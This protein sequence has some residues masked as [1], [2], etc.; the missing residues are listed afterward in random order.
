MAHSVRLYRVAWRQVLIYYLPA[1]SISAGLIAIAQLYLAQDRASAFGIT[2]VLWVFLPL[3]LASLGA[4]LASVVM[5]E[6]LVG[7]KVSPAQA[8]RALP[9]AAGPAVAASVLLF[10]PVWFLIMFVFNFVG[11]ALIYLSAGPPIYI[12]AVALENLGGRAALQ[13]ARGLLADLAGRAFVYLFGIAFGIMLV[14]VVASVVTGAIGASTGLSLE[15]WYV[16]AS[17]I[18]VHGLLLGLLLPFMAAASTVVYLALLNIRQPAP[19]T[20]KANG[21]AAA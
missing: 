4:A 13:R 8:F 9:H 18:G 6:A 12:Q 16:V 7:R 1:F 21:H 3:F 20:R 17:L 19:G 11:N 5:T 14:I 2:M 10:L 15:T